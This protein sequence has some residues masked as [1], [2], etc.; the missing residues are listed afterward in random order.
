MHRGCSGRK[1]HTFANIRSVAAGCQNSRRSSQGSHIVIH[2]CPPRVESE[3]FGH[4]G[5]DQVIRVSKA[6]RVA[7][8]SGGG[9]AVPGQ[10][11]M[12]RWRHPDGGCGA[13][14]RGVPPS[15]GSEGRRASFVTSLTRLTRGSV[16]RSGVH[17]D[18]AMIRAG[19]RASAASGRCRATSESSCG[20]PMHAAS[21]TKGYGGNPPSGRSVS[22][23]HGPARFSVLVFCP[24][25]AG[26][27]VTRSSPVRR[28]VSWHGGA[29]SRA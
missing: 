17:R 1:P 22:P 21:L 25:P 24:L 14:F 29:C 13:P 6:T 19:I 7:P 4:V 15:A 18:V 20:T 11:R 10:V 23:P 5:S 2:R 28:P 9:C 3:P 12:R 26:A 8:R 16:A 27:A